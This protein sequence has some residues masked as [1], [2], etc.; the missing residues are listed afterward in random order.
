MKFYIASGLQ[1]AHPVRR[2][3]Q[4]LKE[5]G[6][7][8]TYDWTQ[9]ERGKS[10]EMHKMIGEAEKEAVAESDFV[11]VLLPGGK[12][13]H[14]EF[15]MALAQNKRIYLYSSSNEI[16]DPSTTTNFYHVSGV[17]KYIG[18]L[19]EFINRLINKEW[20]ALQKV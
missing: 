5:Y 19:D 3:A 15:G 20:E 1:N 9:N 12:G 8:H 10:L 17:E 16:N 14:T 18:D 2:V 7:E 6:F 4:A 11:V 13:T